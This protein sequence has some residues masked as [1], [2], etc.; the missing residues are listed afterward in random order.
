MLLV[1]VGSK[2]TQLPCLDLGV[3]IIFFDPF[4]EF[5]GQN[6]RKKIIAGQDLNSTFQVKC[7]TVL[8]IIGLL[9]ISLS[10]SLQLCSA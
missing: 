5:M 3:K 7:T 10:F 1:V 9:I 6:K 4:M 8:L 2:R